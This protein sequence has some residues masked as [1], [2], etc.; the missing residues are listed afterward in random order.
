MMRLGRS[1]ALAAFATLA[2]CGTSKP[3][4][5]AYDSDACGTCR[6]QISDPR[7]GAELITRHGRVVKFD[8]IDCLVAFYKQATAA[9]D[10][11]SV[12]VSDFQKPGTFIDATRARFVDLGAGRAPMGRGWAAITTADGAAQLGIT[13]Q[14]SIKQWSDLL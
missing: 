14:R 1:L 12:W 7:F 11:G 5:I 4:P 2:A 9:G 10:V 3:E 8:S 13:D 6:M